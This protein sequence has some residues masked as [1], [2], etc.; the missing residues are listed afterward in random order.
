MTGDLEREPVES[1]DALSDLVDTLTP[2]SGSE[3]EEESESEE[4][5]EEEEQESEEEESGEEEE[6]GEE[7]TFT[8]KHDGKEVTLK[9][10][11]L[12][13][14]G[15]KGFD[16][17]AKT[18]AVA[19]ERKQVETVKAQWTER[20]TQQEQA[21]SDTHQRLQALA[22][23]AQRLV[24]Q[25]PSISLA[26]ENAAQYL[27]LKEAHE[28]SKGQ[29]SQALQA[30]Q[31]N[32]QERDRL[33]HATREF[34][35][36]ETWQA[37]SDTLPGWKEDPDAKFAEL[38]KYVKALGLSGEALVDARLEKGFWTLA[39]K[40]KAYDAIQARK[41][42]MKPKEKLTKVAKPSAQNQSA[43]ASDRVKREAAFDKNPSVDA[44]AAIF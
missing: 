6:E 26:H 2:A 22:E 43:R 25:P 36:N 37:L 9:L 16:Y 18:M 29:L 13:E 11:E 21:L 44:L 27:A 7:Q 23:V 4:S 24:G 32:E 41:A 42:E 39:D 35:A 30:I 14:L 15:Q 40:A 12:T 34:R 31:A 20:V 10:S 8:I 38:D 19:E 28:A 1:G 3:Q 17:S 5:E 33:R